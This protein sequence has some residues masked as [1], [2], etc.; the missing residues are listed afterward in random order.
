MT[1][2]SPRRLS[3]KAQ[4]QRVGNSLAQLM[5]SAVTGAKRC[6]LLGKT[7]AFGTLSK[8]YSYVGLIAPLIKRQLSVT[9]PD[10]YLFFST[11]LNLL[12][13]YITLYYK[14][15]RLLQK[16]VFR[17]PSCIYSAIFSILYTVLC[18]YISPDL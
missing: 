6:S 2:L 10:D 13:D 1:E 16:N 15:Q 3:P 7:S 12:Y 11:I 18:V 5:G 17:A 8:M 9:L 4:P 14:C